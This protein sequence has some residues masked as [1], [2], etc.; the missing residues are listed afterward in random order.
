MA[1]ASVQTAKIAAAAVTEPLLATGAVSNRALANASVSIA[2]MN[3]A[4]VFNGQVSVPAAPAPG[5][6]GTLV[7][8]L[9]QT[10]DPV[11]L[12]VSVHFD[13]PRPVLAANQ[14]FNQGFTWKM[15]TNL[16]KPGGQTVFQHN[17]G[18][19]IENPAASIIS[20]TCKAYRL[21]ET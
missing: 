18:L 1:N 4:L 2:K 20:V 3:Q 21:S 13:G 8:N 10:E 6:P 5:Q 11:F 7:V 15:Q 19:L 16:V 12:L 14:L 9:I 17:Y